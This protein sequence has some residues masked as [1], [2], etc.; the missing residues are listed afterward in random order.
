M[1]FTEVIGRKR[2]YRLKDRHKDDRHSTILPRLSRVAG[3]ENI[4]SKVERLGIIEV[5]I[6]ILISAFLFSF[7][8]REK[9]V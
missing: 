7:K 2:N 1:T 9:A 8:L 3:Y 5:L 6:K 4:L